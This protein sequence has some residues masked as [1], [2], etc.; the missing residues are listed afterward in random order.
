MT[1]KKFI[2]QSYRRGMLI[3]ISIALVLAINGIDVYKKIQE[4]IEIKSKGQKVLDIKVD[5]G[6]LEQHFMEMAKKR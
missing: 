6:T 1:M 4:V 5:S 2:S 3:F